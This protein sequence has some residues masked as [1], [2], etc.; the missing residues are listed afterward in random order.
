MMKEDKPNDRSAAA[1]FPVALMPA[2]RKCLVVGAGKAGARKAL[3][4]LEAGAVVTVIAPDAQA[5]IRTL[6]A[7]GRLIWEARPFSA[8]DPAGAF[9]VFAATDRADVNQLVLDSCRRTG[10]L[11]GIVDHGWRQ[12]DFISP[13]VLKRDDGLT[14]AVST[15]GRSCRRS[16]MIRD[17]FSRHIQAVEGALPTVIGTSHACLSLEKREPLA[18]DG[19]KLASAAAMLR[20]IWGVHEFVLLNTCNRIECHAVMSTE[21]ET[22]LLIKRI[23]GFD[24]LAPAES[25]VLRGFDAFHHTALLLS[26]LRSQAAGETHIVAQAKAAFGEAARAGWSGGMMEEWFA[27]ALHLSKAIRAAAPAPAAELEDRCLDYLRS[28]S[29]DALESGLLV[30]GSGALGT[31]LV[32][33]FL[34][35]HPAAPVTWLYHS[36][37]PELPPGGENRLEVR[38]LT[39][40]PA[41]LPATRAI[42]CAASSPEPLLARRHAPLFNPAGPVAI[43]D[44]GVPRNVDPTLPEAAP[45][46]RLADLDDI[47]KRDSLEPAA[48]AAEAGSR[49]VLEHRDLYEKLMRGIRH[50]GD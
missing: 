4:L 15:G 21:P 8:D 38:P 31:R 35:R 41:L 1:V 40:L 47:K 23:L 33:S 22:E 28:A 34:A 46:L 5:D 11:C 9:M 25:F 2:G 48:A 16:R 36:R 24:R 42:A 14:V 6:A 13:A 10:V 44:L 50:P 7:E 26:G 39:D 17:S 20:Q 45:Q 27:S 12:G 3:S 29:P 30:I 18:L 19:V 49:L 37:K 32:E 43:V